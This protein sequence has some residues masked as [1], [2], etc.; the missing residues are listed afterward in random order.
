MIHSKR[1]KSGIIAL[2]LLLCTV[3]GFYTSPMRA[4]KAQVTHTDEQDQII[5][6]LA[7]LVNSEAGDPK[8]LRHYC[9]KAITTFKKN[10]ITDKRIVALIAALEKVKNS[11]SIAVVK[12]A[13]F[14]HQNFLQAE[15]KRVFGHLTFDQDIVMKRLSRAIS[16][17]K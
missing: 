8:P 3:S 4:E 7:D 14:K 2:S 5:L 17:N 13:L 11:N 6:I 10:K 15:F 12:F 16:L 1:S 9:E